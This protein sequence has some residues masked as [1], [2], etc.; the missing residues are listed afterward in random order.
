MSM[1]L[2]R[3][4]DNGST[5]SVSLELINPALGSAVVSTLDIRLPLE[6]WR[7][8]CMQLRDYPTD[9]ASV[10]LVCKRIRPLCIPYLFS[11]LRLHLNGTWCPQLVPFFASSDIAYAVRKI[12]VNGKETRRRDFRLVNIVNAFFKAITNFSNLSECRISSLIINRGQLSSLASVRALHFDTCT[13]DRACR[14]LKPVILNSKIVAIKYSGWRNLI[15]Y[16]GILSLFVQCNPQS[17]TTLCLE[18]PS[19]QNS[20]TG[21]VGLTKP[22]PRLTDVQWNGDGGDILACVALY[23]PNIRRLRLASGIP[24]ELRSDPS[25]LPSSFRFL[26]MKH[27]F[28]GVHCPNVEYLYIQKMTPFYFDWREREELLSEYP[29]MLARLRSF[30][31]H[32]LHLEGRRFS[33]YMSR[34]LRSMPKLNGLRITSSYALTTPALVTVGFKFMSYRR[35]LASF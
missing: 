25:V 1:S 3:P 33:D 11:T 18:I 2:L 21:D 4:K 7:L 5:P 6:L 9:M 16:G 8:V 32:N 35:K 20:S 15:D 14:S 10:S 26:E 30:R 28:P 19:H 24:Q 31:I 12:E 13:Y 22:F 27:V 17:L 23:A 34:L 29:A